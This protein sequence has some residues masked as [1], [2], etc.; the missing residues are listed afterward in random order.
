MYSA[1]YNSPRRFFISEDVLAK[2]NL[3]T[4]EKVYRSLFADAAG[5]TVLVSGDF[6]V[7]P[8][9]ELIAKY[10]GSLPKGKKATE[11]KDRHDG[12]RTDSSLTEFTTKMQAPK[13][14]VLQVYT[15]EAPYT[16]EANIAYVGLSYILDMVYVATLREEE[17]GTYGASANGVVS[18][19]P[20]SMRYLQVAFDTNEA[21][22]D[23]LRELAAKG[24]RDIAENGP[25]AE[26]FDKT[27]KYLEKIIPENHLKLSYWMTTLVNNAVYGY[28]RDAEMIAA[29]K[30][31]TPEKIQAAA[32][33]MIGGGKIELIMR[34]EK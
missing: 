7:E 29:I 19:E 10:F 13:V 12:I 1:V 2:A 24:I 34:P 17:G 26:H 5:A 4:L 25:T 28:D 21:Q 11:W 16:A 27:V 20:Y 18:D 9:T 14:S 22:A 23:G 15:H 33:E 32:A 8:M 3:E 6:E 31:I 30:N